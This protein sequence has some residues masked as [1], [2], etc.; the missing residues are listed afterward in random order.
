MPWRRTV[1][2]GRQR[3][4]KDLAVT[5]VGDRVGSPA[6]DLHPRRQPVVDP[7]ADLA[8]HSVGGVIW[9]RVSEQPARRSP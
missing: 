7:T 5:A 9:Q 2:E 8:D 1:R 3:Q 6:L 4:A